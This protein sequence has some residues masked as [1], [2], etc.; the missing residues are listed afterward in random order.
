MRVWSQ[1]Q[2]IDKMN[3]VKRGVRSVVLTLKTLSRTS[4]PKLGVISKQYSCSTPHSNSTACTCSRG[5]LLLKSSYS[6]SK[7][8]TTWSREE[9]HEDRHG[10]EDKVSRN[11]EEWGLSFEGFKRG[12]AQNTRM[13]KE[14]WMNSASSCGDLKW[15]IILK[16]S[17]DNK[18]KQKL[19]ASPLLHSECRREHSGVPLV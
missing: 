14:A 2:S 16:R 13:K 11:M 19:P 10:K 8:F 6:T 12:A 4:S 17:N 18:I 7:A 9:N 3:Y 1:H 5:G 15:N